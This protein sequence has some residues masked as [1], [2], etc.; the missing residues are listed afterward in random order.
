MPDPIP[1][2]APVTT[3][4][5]PWKSFNVPPLRAS[6]HPAVTPPSI[7]ITVPVT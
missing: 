6:F 2:A 5:L 1:E 7:G 3:A 4:V